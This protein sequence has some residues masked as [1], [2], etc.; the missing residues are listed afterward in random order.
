MEVDQETGAVLRSYGN[1]DETARFRLALE[2]EYRKRS[3]EIKLESDKFISEKMFL[4][5]RETERRVHHIR[6]RQ[7]KQYE[8]LLEGE[9]L[10]VLLD[11]RLSALEKISRLFEEI[12]LKVEQK[13]LTLRED[14][15]LYPVIIKT[16]VKEGLEILGEPAVVLVAPGESALVPS[17][18]LI[19]TVEEQ[20]SLLDCGGCVLLDF[21]TRTIVIDNSMRT[22]W[23]SLKNEY[24]RE[25]SGKYSDVLQGFD[26][27]SRKLRIS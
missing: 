4:A 5:R 6:E 2:G 25:F 13:L 20:E 23:N 7:R 24:L 26:R 9:R 3:A 16:L 10:R 8:T 22:R 27:F 14:H 19:S 17:T 11:V 12:S 15:S 21:R 18:P 1:Q